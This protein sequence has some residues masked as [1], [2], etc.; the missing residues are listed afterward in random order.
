MQNH[1]VDLIKTTTLLFLLSVGPHVHAQANDV[2]CSQCVDTGDIAFEAVVTNKIAKRAVTTSRLD[3]QAVTTNKL[4]PGAVTTEKI[5]SRAVTKDKIKSGAVTT[6]KIQDGAVTGEKLSGSITIPAATATPENDAIEY[7]TFFGARMSL[8]GS[9][10]AGSFNLA[11]PLP[12]GVTITSIQAV[13]FDN[14]DTARVQVEIR[15]MQITLGGGAFIGVV[16]SF[17]TTDADAQFGWRLLESG[18][19]NLTLPDSPELH[20]F[21]RFILTRSTNSTQIASFIVHYE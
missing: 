18:P 4:A 7:D 12:R 6:P 2:D 3:N 8:S 14:V 1:K 17:G 20:Y 16:D 19:L 5:E 13:A 21:I 11:I 15:D 10:T 9:T